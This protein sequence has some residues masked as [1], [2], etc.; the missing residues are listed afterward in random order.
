MKYAYDQGFKKVAINIP[1]SSLI[2]KLSHKP[3]EKLLDK[4][5]IPKDITLR[6]FSIKGYENE[7]IRVKEITPDNSSDMA[8]LVLHGGGFGYKT[9]PYQLW[10]ACHY[11][12][13]LHCRAYILD[14]HLLPEYPFPAAYEDALLMYQ[15][16]VTYAAELAIHPEKIIVLGDSAGG[17]LAAN[18]CNV[19]QSKGLPMPCCQVL[20]YPVT[21][22]TMLTDSMK[23]FLDTPMWNA[24][25]NKK[26]WD[27][28][29][30]DATDEEINI[31]VPMKNVLPE[32]LPPTYIETAE[33]DCLHDEGIAYAKHIQAIARS[34]EVNETKRTVHGYDRLWKHPITQENI[35]KRIDFIRK[36]INICVCK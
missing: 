7:Q 9:A 10:N 12:S 11:A 27:M 23:R 17:A 4:V 34:I 13:K 35:G 26:M 6:D 5:K 19:A 14:Y 24:K 33:F 28:Y 36:C 30:K 32:I 2:C 31:A 20:I 25:N 18:V 8:M 15:Y 29:L 22:Y 1:F 16:L 21:D 3:M